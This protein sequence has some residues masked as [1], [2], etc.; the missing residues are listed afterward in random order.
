MDYA[1]FRLL[2]IC[3]R[4]I[5]CSESVLHRYVTKISQLVHEF[6]YKPVV[7]EYCGIGGHSV[8]SCAKWM[9]AEEEAAEVAK[10]KTKTTGKGPK[11]RTGTKKKKPR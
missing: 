2:Q 8:K 11:G 6:V 9:V 1:H 7:C 4:Y 10:N 3:A 5:T